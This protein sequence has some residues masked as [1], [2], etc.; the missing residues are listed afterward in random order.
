M[1]IPYNM[2]PCLTA[3]LRK[4]TAYD[5]TG[6]IMDDGTYHIQKRN[7][8]YTIYGVLIPPKNDSLLFQEMGEIKTGTMILYTYKNVILFFHDAVKIGE[9]QIQSYIVYRDAVY[10]VVGMSP[11]NEDGVHMKYILQKYVNRDF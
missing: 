7:P 1:G 3:F 2:T 9:E 11:R 5:E 6:M 10:R 4:M 8:E